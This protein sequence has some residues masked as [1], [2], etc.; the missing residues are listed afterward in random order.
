MKKP[1]PSV[2][3][4]AAIFFVLLV[5]YLGSRMIQ[6]QSA[7]RERRLLEQQP[8]VRSQRT[9]MAAHLQAI[10]DA[11]K[12]EQ[13]EVDQKNQEL[14]KAGIHGEQRKRELA[15]TMREAEQEMSQTL[16]KLNEK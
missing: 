13:M 11:T 14:T 6:Y 9:E 12:K 3:I 7:Q 4:L 10:N 16:Q 15:K 5:A 1:L 8:S 2:V